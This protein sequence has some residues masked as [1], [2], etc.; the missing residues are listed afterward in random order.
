MF[1]A[2]REFRLFV[3]LIS[4]ETQLYFISLD[5]LVSAGR[6]CPVF[7]LYLTVRVNNS[8]LANPEWSCQPGGRMWVFVVPFKGDR[9]NV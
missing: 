1:G 8:P 6:R 9:R 4:V 5:I 7:D 3:M 2:E